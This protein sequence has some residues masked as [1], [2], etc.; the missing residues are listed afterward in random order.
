MVMDCE[1]LELVPDLFVNV[2]KEV[3]CCTD[4]GCVQ[5]ILIDLT[6]YV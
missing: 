2:E 4:I 1:F 6:S 3:R 5:D